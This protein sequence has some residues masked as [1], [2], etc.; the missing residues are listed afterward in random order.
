[1]IWTSVIKEVMGIGEK[2]NIK[3]VIG[4]T[5]LKMCVMANIIL[6]IT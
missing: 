3:W 4:A 2:S 1:M 6:W 5:V